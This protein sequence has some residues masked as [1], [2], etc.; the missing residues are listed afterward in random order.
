MKVCV[1]GMRGFPNV[2]GGV[3]KHC[4]AIYPRM[5]EDFELVVLRRRPY[6]NDTEGNHFEHISFVDLPSTRIKGFE[7]LFHSFLCTLK[8][9]KI[10][11]DLVHIHNIGACLF[12]SMIRRAGIPMV[13]TYHSPNY[14]HKKWSRFAKALLRS[15]EKVAF[16]NASRVI[17][18]NKFQM[19][20]A[21]NWVQEKSFF[22]PNGIPVPNLTCGTDRLSK[23][24]LEKDKY[25]LAVG[26]ITPEKGFDDLIAAFNEAK[27]GGFKLAIA[28][29]VEFEKGYMSKLEK[30]SD[31]SKVVFTGYVYGEDLQQLYNNAGLFVLSS[32][33]EGFPLVLLEAM[34][35][36]LDVIVSDIP[37]THLVNLDN[38]CYYPLGDVSRLAELLKERTQAARKKAYNLSAYNWESIAKE[39]GQV[40]T[41]CYSADTL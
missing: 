13:L 11:P 19:Q 18:V 10:K 33:N 21:P 22:I 29:G 2:E 15:C 4:E 12:S 3:E 9:I 32:H 36:N 16:K 31:K 5:G 28:G 38:G 39:T 24:G 25:I 8:V 23:W 7:A 34:S 30:I 26:R 1:F 35:Y 14:E 41:S 17:Y 27:L 40:F 20:K 37:A 6:V